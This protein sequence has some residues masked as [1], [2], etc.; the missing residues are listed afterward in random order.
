MKRTFALKTLGCK[1]NQYEEQVI[2]ENMLKAGFKEASAD[3]ADIFILNSCTVTDQADKKT[4]RLL[5]R[6]KKENPDVKICVTGC[7]A[8]FEKD[9]DLL[10]SLDE[11]D[12]VVPG[13][14]KAKI[15]I[16]LSSDIEPGIAGEIVSEKITGFNTHTRAFLKVQD[17][18]DQKCTYCKVNLVRG[19]SRSR[20]E[21]DIIREFKELLKAGYKE[22][23]ITGIC[24]GSWKSPEGEG[25][26]KIVNSITRIDGDFRIRLSSIEPNH[27]TEELMDAV[28]SSKKICKHLHIPLQSGSDSLLKRMNRRYQTK[29]FALLVGRLREK[30]P[31]IG[32][33]MD[34]ISGFPGETEEDVKNTIAFIRKT[35]PSR[36]HVFKYSDREGTPSYNFIDKVPGDIA[37]KRVECLISEG[38]I[39]QKEFCR[40][41]KGRQVEVLVEDQCREGVLEGYTAEYVRVHLNGFEAYKGDI[42]CIKCEKMD[43]KGPFLCVD[44]VRKRDKSVKVKTTK[45]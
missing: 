20:S 2:R 1:V 42:V 32:I 35:K 40:R 6:V 22:I 39:L 18:C 33:S 21:E 14:D 28:S 11:V 5:R 8:V 19:P 43:E 9:I 29:D 25:L 41:F 13:K 15:A 16:K 17:G 31:D 27:V 26:E 7:F 34:V 38:N 23:V 45:A 10:K 4:V 44:N 36:L 30:M 3:R 12:M 37:K 24:L